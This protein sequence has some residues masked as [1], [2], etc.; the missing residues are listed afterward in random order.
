M[1]ERQVQLLLIAVATSPGR[2]IYHR[3]EPLFIL[4]Q[5]LTD[6]WSR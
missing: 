5:L 2:V 1:K 6:M 4:S 3:L